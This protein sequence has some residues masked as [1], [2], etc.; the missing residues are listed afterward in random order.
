MSSVI[1]WFVFLESG[2]GGLSRTAGDGGKP[3]DAQDILAKNGTFHFLPR[4]RCSC[5]VIKFL[6]SKFLSPSADCRP[7]ETKHMNIQSLSEGNN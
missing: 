3:P 4:Q 5:A 6:P 2:D 1:F 7:G